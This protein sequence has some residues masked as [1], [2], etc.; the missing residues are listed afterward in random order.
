MGGTLVANSIASVLKSSRVVPYFRRPFADRGFS[1]CN[2]GWRCSPSQSHGCPPG[3]GRYGR[4]EILPRACHCR[5]RLRIR[6]GHS[7]GSC[8]PHRASAGGG[9]TYGSLAGNK[10]TI[11][12]HR[13]LIRFRVKTAISIATS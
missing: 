13:G 10:V 1:F 11:V 4:A 8:P 2:A 12:G 9:D 6:I 3:G 5:Q 7:G